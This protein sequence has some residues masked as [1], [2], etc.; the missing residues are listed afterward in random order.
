MMGDFAW[1]GGRGA[2]GRYLSWRMIYPQP[3]GTIVVAP[4]GT[5]S[6]QRS[7]ILSKRSRHCHRLSPSLPM[8][9]Q[10]GVSDRNGE[11]YHPPAARRRSA[12][13]RFHSRIRVRLILC[14]HLRRY[15]KTKPGMA[16]THCRVKMP[17]A[18][19]DATPMVTSMIPCRM[20]RHYLP[21]ANPTKPAPKK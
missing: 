4:G 13:G 11:V 7:A 15:M 2:S 16:T 10:T 12:D 19:L 14:A 17:M 5:H 3:G 1:L 18:L 21:A 6:R 20:P 8:P 9:R